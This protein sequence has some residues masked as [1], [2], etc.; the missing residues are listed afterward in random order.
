M[1]MRNLLA[2]ILP[3]LLMSGVYRQ[4][5]VAIDEPIY[6]SETVQ[7]INDNQSYQY[8][9]IA[10]MGMGNESQIVLNGSGQLN[11]T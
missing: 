9:N 10:P 8:W 1:T 6:E 7:E 3:I 4:A 5:E 2:F 11:F